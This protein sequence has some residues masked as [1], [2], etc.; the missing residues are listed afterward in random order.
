MKNTL[1][2]ALGGTAGNPYLGVVNWTDGNVYG[3]NASDGFQNKIQ[4]WRFR[5]RAWVDTLRPSSAT[6]SPEFPST[7]A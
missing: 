4:N 7:A 3:A 5:K 1:P 6:T 2:A